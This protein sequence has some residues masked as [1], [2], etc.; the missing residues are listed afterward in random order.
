MPQTIADF[1]VVDEA[2]VERVWREHQRP[3]DPESF[4]A[5][6]TRIDEAA[7]AARGQLV[8]VSYSQDVNAVCPK[9]NDEEPFRLDS[10]EA[11]IAVLGYC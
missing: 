4:A 2:Q 1:Y 10:A 8:E 9:C 11:M 3:A 6:R 5:A 7:R